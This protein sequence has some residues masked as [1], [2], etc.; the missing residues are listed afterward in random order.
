MPIGNLL[1]RAAFAIRFGDI[2][3]MLSDRVNESSR[4]LHDREPAERVRQ[5]APW[6]TIDSDPFPSVVDGKIVWIIDAYT[7]TQN[8]PN[9]TRQDWTTAISDSR[10]SADSLLIGQQ[11][12]YVRNSVKAVVDAYDGT[13]TLYAQDEQDPVLQ[14][15][16][17][18]VSEVWL[19]KGC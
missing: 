3:L 12:N 19:N 15:L 8:Y 1:T 5:A 18:C 7:T 6:L 13:V 2:N 14:L 11:V 4:L 10:T 9:S 16:R 17:Q